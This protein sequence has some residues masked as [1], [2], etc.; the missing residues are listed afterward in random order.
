M[1][2]IV[3]LDY[4]VILRLHDAVMTSFLAFFSISKTTCVK[5]VGVAPNDAEYNCLQ[6]SEKDFIQ[7]N[8]FLSDFLLVGIVVLLR[9][10]ECK[11]Y[12]FLD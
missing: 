10:F 1:N 7:K 11:K 8:T 5:I 6:S 2:L 12:I 3:F 9:S 4:D